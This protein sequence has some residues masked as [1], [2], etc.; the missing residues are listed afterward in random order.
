[1]I[2]QG[3]YKDKS[4]R[5]YEICINRIE[6]TTDRLMFMTQGGRWVVHSIERDKYITLCDY[7]HSANGVTREEWEAKLKEMNIL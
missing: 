1:M 4:E 7:V 6:V 2:Q 3:A 5:L